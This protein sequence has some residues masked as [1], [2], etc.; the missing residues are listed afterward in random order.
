[1]STSYPGDTLTFAVQAAP[2]RQAGSWTRLARD[3][4][5]LGYR[6]LLVPEH[7]GSGGPL[8]GMAAAGAVTTSL[9]VGSL[10]LS[11]DFHHPVLLA[12]EFMTL[13][14]LIGGRLEAGLGAG[15]MRRDYERL[16]QTMDPPGARIAR[17]SAFVDAFLSRCA[18]RGYEGPHHRFPAA[19]VQPA[20]AG[21]KPVIVLGGG[22]RRMLD[23]AVRRA[24]IVN[25][26]APM[27]TGLR[28]APLGPEATHRA[29]ADRVAHLARTAHELRRWPRLQCLAYETHVTGDAWAAARGVADGFGIPADEVLASPLTLIGS[30]PELCDKIQQCRETLGIS[31]WVVKSPAMYDFAPVVARLRDM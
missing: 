4:E 14:A 8:V 22:G 29:F 23:L 24:D 16:G 25:I 31:Y 2:S 1:M 12:E 17:L 10:V 15:W 5:D 18:G 28:N 19:D 6:A 26:G 3:A 20:A 7:V 9:S 11:A 30:V 21:W 27:T 13:A